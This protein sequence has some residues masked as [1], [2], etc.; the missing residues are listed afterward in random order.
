MEKLKC[1]PKPKY[2][3]EE[4]RARKNLRSRA[5]YERKKNPDFVSEP[6]KPKYTPE[7][8]LARD[9]EINLT[10]YYAHKDERRST[11]SAIN[12]RSTQRRPWKAIAVGAIN[13]AKKRGIPY[14]PDLLEWAAVRYTGKCE[15][16]GLEFRPNRGHGCGPAPFSPSIDRIDPALGY[17]KGNCR[18]ILHALNALKGAGTDE[19]AITIAKAF[20]EFSQRDRS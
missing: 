20:V 4:L 18:F 13:R 11:R 10:W 19:D 7:E 9:R 14:D 3:P 6:K 8:R 16:T 2:T 5:Y 17:T 12:L 15:L 1:G